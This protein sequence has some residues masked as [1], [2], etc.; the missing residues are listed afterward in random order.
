MILQRL[1]TDTNTFLS[2]QASSIKTR[3][4]LQ[5]AHAACDRYFILETEK[6]G[7]RRT[8]KQLKAAELQFAMKGNVAING[9]TTQPA[10]FIIL[11]ASSPLVK[12]HVFHVTDCI[13][14]C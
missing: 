13:H 5:Q 8:S 4:W 6:H 12:I 1:I 11:V 7:K 2:A 10:R 9:K 3:F 14:K